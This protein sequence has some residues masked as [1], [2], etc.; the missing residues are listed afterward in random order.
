M[1][2]A[3]IWKDTYYTT[4]ADTLNYRI[5]LDGEEIY[6]GKAVKYPDADELKINMNKVCSNYLESDIDEL[7]NRMSV[8]PDFVTEPGVRQ[9]DLEVDGTVVENYMFVYDWSYDRAAI[10]DMM[11]IYESAPGL[12]YQNYPINGHFIPG[13][14]CLRTYVWFVN[15]ST[16]DYR[17]SAF[18]I[19]PEDGGSTVYPYTKKVKCVP[20]VLYYL[21]SYGGWD[22]FV[23]EGNTT[24]RDTFTTYT[25]DRAFDNNTL[26]FENNKYVQEIKTTYVMNTGLLT[27]EQSRNLAKN[28]IGSIKVYLQNV[29]EGWTKPV[30]ITDSSVDY[31]TYA[32]NGQ[33]LSQYKITVQESQ[34][35][36]RR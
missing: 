35:K 20:Y 1:I 7:L 19:L 8:E 14:L 31:Q 34:S 9:F 3:P 18:V 26:E 2:V 4:T 11:A 25:T 21:N 24:K 30:V 10:Q 16:A 22:A 15:Q 17:N 33:K 6:A 36:I 5:L 13:M 28:L 29:E 32:T 23:I 27:D 12:Y